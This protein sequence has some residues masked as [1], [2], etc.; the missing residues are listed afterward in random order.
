M[1]FRSHR[2]LFGIFVALVLCAGVS[3]SVGA[4]SDPKKDLERLKKRI[5]EHKK[6][7][8]DILK[9]ESSILKNLQETDENLSRLKEAV[10]S[11]RARERR[12]L[13]EKQEAEKLLKEAGKKADM[14]R[15]LLAASLRSM[16]ARGKYGYVSLF[17]SAGSAEELIGAGMLFKKLVESNKRAISSFLADS[18]EAE[19]RKRILDR[20]LAALSALRAELEKS[21]SEY[22]MERERKK[23]LLKLVSEQKDFYIRSIK[24]MEAASANLQK[25]VNKLSAPRTGTESLPDF[26]SRKGKYTPPVEG[27]KLGRRF[28]EHFDAR[29]QGMV[30]FKGLE[31]LVPEGT[32]VRAIAPGRVVF[33]GWF[34]G[35]GKMVILDH[36]DGYFSLY[37][38][39]SRIDCKLHSMV[40]SGETIGISGST[41]SLTGPRLYFE[42]RHK[43]V[44]ENPLKWLSL[45]GRKSGRST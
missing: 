13:K 4:S 33:A 37:G 8:G 40:S 9:K 17:L 20:K 42:I 12:I 10:E 45:K 5:E 29:I 23:M 44:A 24:E 22:R 19:K 39:L 3:L 38:N 16:Y 14:S 28:G 32:A 7:V 11:L 35:Y 36:G 2:I 43:G 27:F 25:L 15:R 21:R 18:K 1:N 41:G 26:V 31:F 34:E 6:Q 30:R